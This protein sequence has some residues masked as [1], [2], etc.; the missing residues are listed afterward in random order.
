MAIRNIGAALVSAGFQTLSLSNSTA[1]GLNS[2]CL[3]G[4]W[5]HISVETNA[6]RYRDDGVTPAL[7]TGVNLAVGAHWLLDVDA[8]NLKFQRTTGTSKVSIQAYKYKG[9]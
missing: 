7:T 5:F 9:T 6:C 8:A 3:S 2:T 4:K 1:S